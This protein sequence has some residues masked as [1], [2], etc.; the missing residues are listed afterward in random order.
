M[1]QQ[2]TVALADLTGTGANAAKSVADFET[3]HLYVTGTFVGTVVAEVSG[4]GT[5]WAPAGA[6]VT[7]PAVIALPASASMARL[8]CTAFT[9]GTIKSHLA[10]RDSDRAG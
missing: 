3:A 6:A 1:A 4:D 10:G 9:S 2:R 7:A 5:N 8:N